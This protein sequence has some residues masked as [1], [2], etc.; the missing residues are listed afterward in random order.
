M[1]KEYESL[2]HGK[3]LLNHEISFEHHRV[4]E[5]LPGEKHALALK[6]ETLL[7]RL[8]RHVKKIKRLFK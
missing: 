6:P 4:M 3:V 8:R 5:G 7:D 2:K 1:S